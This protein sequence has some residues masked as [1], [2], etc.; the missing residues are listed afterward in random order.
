MDNPTEIL[1]L[2]CMLAQRYIQP[3]NKQ[4]HTTAQLQQLQTGVLS[5]MQSER[6]CKAMH[7]L[8]KA[9]KNHNGYIL[10]TEK[11]PVWSQTIHEQRRT[12]LH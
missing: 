7:R 1:I 8:N 4:Q 12:G 11:F 3:K 10:N 6:V 5:G 9:Y 2:G